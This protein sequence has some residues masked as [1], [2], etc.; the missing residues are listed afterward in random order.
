M[1]KKLI[2]SILVVAL[3]NLMGC[4]SSELV[5]VTEYK[6]VEEED[7]PDDI[8]VITKDSQEYH[9]SDSNFLIDSDTL[10]WKDILHLSKEEL[11]FE[12]KFALGEIK[13]IQL[14]EVSQNYSTLISMTVSKYQKI[15]AESGKP[16][17]IYVISSDSTRYHFMKNDYYIEKDT[18]YGK[19]K[20][21]FAAREE[22]VGRK[23][24]ISDIESI[25]FESFNWL[26][27]SLLI[28]GIAVTAF[29]AFVFLADW[30]PKKF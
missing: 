25:E 11:P 7:K 16:D 6:Q 18:L 12:G 1:Y 13:S 4:Y 22:L 17:E 26:T 19:G 21:L 15:E 5:N 14:K 24:A 28:L 23:I 29:V 10:Y 2:S 8:R 3:L 27:T 30:G 20:L 9:F